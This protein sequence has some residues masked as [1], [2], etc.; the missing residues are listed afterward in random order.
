MVEAT[1]RLP[2]VYGE[3]ILPGR[4]V[5]FGGYAVVTTP[6]A[7]ELVRGL[8]HH[9]P[10]H[11]AM[12]ES[13]ER[14]S[15]DRMAAAMPP[16]NSI[17]G[18]GGGTVIDAAKYVAEKRGGRLYLAPT[19]TSGDGAFS[20]TIAVREDGKPVGMRGTVAPAAILVDYAVIRRG[21][22]IYNRS[23]YGDLLRLPVSREDWRLAC[24]AGKDTWSDEIYEALGELTERSFA[25]A[26]HV[27]ALS[28]RGI[29]ELMEL[30]AQSIALCTEHPDRR[31]STGAEHLI[32]WNL[33]QVTG[34]H[35]VHGQVVALG[36]V[37]SA[38]LQEYAPERM[39]H[40]LREAQLPYRPW[41]IGITW[42]EFERTLRTV[43]EYNRSV[44]R[45]YTILDERPI[46]PEI[47]GDIRHVLE[48][49]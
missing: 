6:P 13:L 24:R 2:I 34:K 45:H 39:I 12:A 17:V 30:L 19:L 21:D 32:A 36:N 35:F 28:D 38:V 15:L 20:P 33:E 26:P 16:V 5:D 31:L 46:T 29:R 11:V 22:P 3:N 47:L 25:L 43:Q 27:G 7:W 8:L 49:D 4:S 40:A 44:R 14:A 41:E 1:V 10:A 23:G 42:D 9:P 18:I 48:G 37:V